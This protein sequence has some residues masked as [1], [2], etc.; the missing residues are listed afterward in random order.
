MFLTLL[1]VTFA[2]ALGTSLLV[3]WLFRNALSA[4]LG[5]IVAQEIASAWHKYLNF[6]LCV[7]GVSGGVPVGHLED[8]V[9][10]RRP[11]GVEPL[12]LTF[13]RWVLEVYRALIGTLQSIAWL[14]LVFFVAALIAYVIMRGLERRNDR[15]G[16]SE[17]SE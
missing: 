10:S 14:L 16:A 8:Y 2:I 9:I 1:A 12:M 11:E 17:R 7:V 5:R 4:I 3:V 15:V 13:N 6:A